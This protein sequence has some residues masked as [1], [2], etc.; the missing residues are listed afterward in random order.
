VLNIDS[1]VVT[2][3]TQKCGPCQIFRLV[4]PEKIGQKRTKKGIVLL[5]YFDIS[6]QIS[7]EIAVFPG[8]VPFRRMTSLD[9]QK[10]DHLTLSAIE[11]TL[12]IG[13]HADAPSHYHIKGESIEQRSLKIYFGAAQVIWARDSGTN[14][15]ELND[16]ATPIISAP[17]VLLKTNSFP[18]P[19]N[20]NSN[21]K[22]LSVELIEFLYGKGVRL[23]GIDTPS[24][25]P[26]DSKDLPAHKAIHKNDMAVLEGLTLTKVPDGKYFLCALPL[27]IKGG[28][29]SPV[30]AVLWD[31]QWLQNETR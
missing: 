9:I 11:T 4:F 5:E 22:G 18:N 6:P 3:T 23:V 29:A 26:S 31:L 21:F 14:R 17:R 12:H 2:K 20:W 10:G 19:Q 13:A 7:S 16:L 30:R 28:D 25:D 15:V 24:I 27:A 8:D 1:F